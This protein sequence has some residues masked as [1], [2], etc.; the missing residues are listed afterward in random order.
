MKYLGI[1]QKGDGILLFAQAGP[2]SQKVSIDMFVRKVLAPLLAVSVT[3]SAVGAESE[4]YVKVKKSTFV[5]LVDLLVKRGVLEKQEGSSLVEEAESESKAQETQSKV[6]PPT[7]LGAEPAGAATPG[8]AAATGVAGAA[9]SGAGSGAAP[10]ATV[11]PAAAA[12]AGSSKYVAYVPQF[13]KDEIR[14]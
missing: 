13:V 5:N 2:R 7:T 4:T 9:A 10:A 11:A 6:S 12:K 8:A 3:A 14:N 1:S